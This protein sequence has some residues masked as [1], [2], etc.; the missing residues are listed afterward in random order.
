MK[1]QVVRE[2]VGGFVD[3]EA[4]PVREEQGHGVGRGGAAVVVAYEERAPRRNALQA[5]DAESW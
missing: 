2:S 5:R 4:V 3:A 1:A